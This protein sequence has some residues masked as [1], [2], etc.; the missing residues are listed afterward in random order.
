M[1]HPM[2]FR[3]ATQYSIG[4]KRLLELICD[5][6]M[7]LEEAIKITDS[8]HKNFPGVKKMT[9]S[10]C[11]KEVPKGLLCEQ[12]VLN[13]N[14]LNSRSAYLKCDSFLCSEKCLKEHK[15]ECHSNFTK[16]S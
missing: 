2:H 4:P 6:S 10:N 12:L 14:E 15:E 7:P 11:D 9:C 3:L 13:T 1:K 16:T 5:T 8:F